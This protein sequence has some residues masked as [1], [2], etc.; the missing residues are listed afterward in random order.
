MLEEAIG[1][2]EAQ[3]PGPELARAYTRMG[4]HL[5]VAGHSA[6]AIPWT[7]KAIALA[8]ELGL[9]GE[10]VLALQ[11]RGAARAQLGDRGGLEDLREALQRGIELGLGNETA[12]AYNNLAYELWFWEG[13][14]AAQ[15][16]WDE[17]EAFC[18]V[19]GF[20]TMAVWAQGG[21]LESLFDLGDWDRVLRTAAE[22]LLWEREHGPT[23]VSVIAL[24]Y[25]GW[26]H[27]RRGGIEEAAS[28]AQEV[29]PLAR[30]IGYADYLAPPLVLSAEVALLQGQDALAREHLRDFVRV[31]AE[32]DDYRTMLLPLVVRALVGLGDVGEAVELVE[33]VRSPSTVRL[34][35]SLLSSRA[36]V[37]E[38]RGDLARA[39][40]LYREAAVG[41]GEYRFGLECARLSLGAGRCLLALGREE[42]GVPLLVEAGRLLRPLGA[43]P[44]LEEVEALLGSLQRA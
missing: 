42:E 10:A 34:Q 41:W 23:R 16:M 37:A 26:V 31:T 1:L 6:G 13:P 35:L 14:A 29:L 21:A 22:M 30:E 44:L 43:R 18:R 7:E 27:L 25:R 33:G 36:T 19:R 15:A 11:Y 3:E 32:T 28:T 2:L 8:D 38:A 5:Y 20:R 40:D 9:E 17:M 12:N 39:A 24:T 4:G